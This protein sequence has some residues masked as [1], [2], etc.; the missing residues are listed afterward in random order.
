M[1][2][3]VSFKT[4]VTLKC[5]YW[6]VLKCSGRKLNK[7]FSLKLHLPKCI[8]FLNYE[9]KNEEKNMLNIITN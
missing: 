4:N 6:K 5:I 2:I 1:W 8:F 9:G 3:I 7:Q